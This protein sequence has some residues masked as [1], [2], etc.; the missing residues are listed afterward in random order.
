MIYYDGSIYDGQWLNGLCGGYGT[1]T[2]NKWSEIKNCPKSIT[3]I[4]W[5]LNDLKHGN[6]KCFGINGELIY[7][8]KFENNKPID[9]YPS[10]IKK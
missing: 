3:Y 4:G 8:G 7:N 2:V 9:K 5:F 10:K 6:G 1:L